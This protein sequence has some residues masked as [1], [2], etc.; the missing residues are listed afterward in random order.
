MKITLFSPIL[1]LL[2]V[3]STTNASTAPSKE[4]D[5]DENK[6]KVSTTQKEEKSAS[7]TKE[8]LVPTSKTST[9]SLFQSKDQPLSCS[10]KIEKKTAVE[11]AKDFFK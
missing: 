11:Q 1:L 9:N 6:K 8:H 4:K 5:C 10:K 7:I 2:I 3:C